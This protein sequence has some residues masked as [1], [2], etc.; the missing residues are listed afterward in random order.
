MMRGMSP[1]ENAPPG[2][3]RAPA[4]KEKDRTERSCPICGEPRSE[5]YDPFCSRRCADIDLHR[6][7]KGSYV[8]PGSSP[9]REPGE[10]EE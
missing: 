5:R 3:R 7:L 8:I 6:W 4:K 10:K 2:A 9:T 1:N